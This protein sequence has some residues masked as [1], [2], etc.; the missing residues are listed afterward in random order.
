MHG[1]VD[2]EGTLAPGNPDLFVWGPDGFPEKY[3]GKERVVYGHWNNTAA[4][5]NGYPQPYITN[6]T[7][8][9]DTIAHG[10]LTAM[11]FPDCKVFQSKR[12]R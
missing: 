6:R 11:R 3:S 7:Y 5:Q 1:G 4:D 8:G 9:I 12:Y 2:L 10:V